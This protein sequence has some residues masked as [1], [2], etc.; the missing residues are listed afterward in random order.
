[1]LLSVLS[2][3]GYDI[4]CTNHGFS[5]W[6]SG[7]RRKCDIIRLPTTCPHRLCPPVYPSLPTL[8]SRLPRLLRARLWTGFVDVLSKEP[9]GEKSK[10][11]T[12]ISQED[13]IMF[14]SVLCL[15]RGFLLLGAQQGERF[16]PPLLVWKYRIGSQPSPQGMDVWV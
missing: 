2:T 13:S 8:A 16:V 3:S 14:A 6:K 5:S 10:L 1:M 9:P 11:V 15:S 12:W 4:L 7:N